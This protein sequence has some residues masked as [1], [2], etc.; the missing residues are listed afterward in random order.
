MELLVERD[1]SIV[2]G[3][4]A[5]GLCV[6]GGQRDAVVDVED[7]VAAAGG[8]DGGRGFDAVLLG[9][10]LAFDELAAADEAGARGLLACSVSLISSGISID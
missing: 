4:L 3:Q 10:H 8:P 7:A 2:V 1:G 5:G 6:L 9:V